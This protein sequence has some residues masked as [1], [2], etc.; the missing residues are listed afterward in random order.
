MIDSECLHP[1]QLWYLSAV[2]S[3]QV[4]GG[5]HADDAIA[6]EPISNTGWT[7]LVD[8]VRTCRPEQKIWN[9][10]QP[11]CCCFPMC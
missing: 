4:V 1:D 6:D 2:K 3:F 11:Q 5:L 9:C 8:G 10:L 7:W